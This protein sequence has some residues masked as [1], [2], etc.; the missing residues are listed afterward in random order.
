MNL[1]SNGVSVKLL[2]VLF[3]MGGENIYNNNECSYY[4]IYFNILLFKYN[5]YIDLPL[6]QGLMYMVIVTQIMRMSGEDNG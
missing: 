6:S 2:F 5:F 3:C 1:S 4:H